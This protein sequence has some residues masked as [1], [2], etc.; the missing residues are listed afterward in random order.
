MN[1]EL[2]K[3]TKW[4]FKHQTRESDHQNNGHQQGR[5]MWPNVFINHKSSKEATGWIVHVVL[6]A[7]NF[8]GNMYFISSQN[9]HFFAFHP[10]LGVY[11][12]VSCLSWERGESLCWFECTKNG[13]QYLFE[14]SDKGVFD[15]MFLNITLGYIQCVPVYV[16]RNQS[17]GAGVGRCLG[18]LVRPS[19]EPGGRVPPWVDHAP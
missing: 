12:V 19:W 11:Q 13:N 18:I 10:S 16:P 5:V 17:W 7:C 14:P 8:Y 3:D 6:V 2:S 15:T 9:S 4:C 1:C